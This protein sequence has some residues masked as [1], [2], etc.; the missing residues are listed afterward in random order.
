MKSKTMLFSLVL[1]L[2]FAS[3]LMAPSLAQVADDSQTK[4]SVAEVAKV[5]ESAETSVR[6]TEASASETSVSIKG[7]IRKRR[8]LLGKIGSFA[9]NLFLGSEYPDGYSSFMSY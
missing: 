8:S 5:P 1:S 9:A 7:E 6:S 2:S 3:P 4:A